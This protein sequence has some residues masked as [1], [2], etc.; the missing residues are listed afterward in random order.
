MWMVSLAQAAPEGGELIGTKAPQWDVTEWINST[1]LALQQLRGKVVLVRW[2]TGPECPYCA[3]SAPRL[4]VLHDTYHA[5]GLVVI[6]FYHH[7]SPTPL[8]RR[9]VAQLVK[10]YR[11]RFPVAI[12]PEW[13]T[14]KRW[15]LDPSTRAQGRIPSEAEGLDGHDRAWT[16]A[17]FLIDQQGVIQY[18]HPGGSYSGADAKAMEAM[19]Q[20][21][22]GNP[23]PAQP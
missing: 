18:V 13:Q 20:Q 15:W 12:D 21:L 5:K 4:N 11:F 9:H 1:P 6:G 22:L 8:T 2:W 7:K 14:L 19:I 23:Q 16:S 10:R 17:S 3:A